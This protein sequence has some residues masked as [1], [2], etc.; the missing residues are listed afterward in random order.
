MTEKTK[1]TIQKLIRHLFMLAVAF[2]SLV[3]FYIAIINAFKVEKDIYANPLTLPLGRLTLENLKRNFISPNFNVPRAYF[4]TIGL[5]LVTLLL[6][7]IIS[8]CFPTF[9]AGTDRLLPRRLY[10][11][12]GWNA[13]PYPGNPDTHYPDPSFW[14]Y[15]YCPRAGA[16][17]YSLV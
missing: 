16:A 14:T 13:Y 1:R 6:T 9:S 4:F 17:A 11:A 8:P 12:A 2:I 15:A 3:P 5:V 10:A 7:V